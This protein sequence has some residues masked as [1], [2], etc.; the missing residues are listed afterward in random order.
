MLRAA[1][2]LA[3][4]LRKQGYSVARDILDRSLEEALAYARQMNYRYL[5]VVAGLGEDVEFISLTDEKRLT[6]SWV[7][8][9]QEPLEFLKI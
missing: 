2:E 7:Q 6:V 9:Q 5:A 8:L 1:Q 4:K 3:C